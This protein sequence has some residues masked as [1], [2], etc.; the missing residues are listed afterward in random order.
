VFFRLYLVC[1]LIMLR[2]HLVR[3]A[4]S[5]SLGY[6]NRVSFTFPFVIKAYIQQQPA[7][8][9]TTFC[10]NLFF[11]ASWAMRACDFNEKSGHMSMLDATWLFIISFTTI[12]NSYFVD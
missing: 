1:R 4:S 12:G 9:L 5:Q 6:L 8:C 11:I 10:I 3:D 7:L 2:S